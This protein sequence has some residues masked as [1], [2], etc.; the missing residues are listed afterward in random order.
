MRPA[1]RA[2]E[3]ERAG[4]EDC[5]AQLRSAS[6]D[7]RRPTIEIEGIELKG[8]RATVRVVT[9]AAGQTRVKDDLELRLEG[10][11]WLIEALS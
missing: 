10:G 2:R 1:D 9:R 4:G 11:R 5:I 6:E 7:V 8:D 3:A